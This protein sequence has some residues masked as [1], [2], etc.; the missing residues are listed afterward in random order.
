MFLGGGLDPKSPL[1]LV[2]DPHLTQR[3]WTP[4]VH[5]TCQMASRSTERLPFNQDAR[6]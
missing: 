1:P 4:Q 2:R 5:Y 6:V 3:P